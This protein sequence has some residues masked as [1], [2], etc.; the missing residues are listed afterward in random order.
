MGRGAAAQSFLQRSIQGAGPAAFRDQI[1]REWLLSRNPPVPVK[2]TGRFFSDA[3]ELPSR[4]WRH[5]SQ[6]A[7]TCSWEA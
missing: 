4:L 2:W 1:T 5:L 7:I 3:P 6:L